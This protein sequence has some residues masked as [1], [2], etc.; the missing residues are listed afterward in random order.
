[1]SLFDFVFVEI[2]AKVANH[3]ILFFG[4]DLKITF[5]LSSFLN[6][7]FHM[8]EERFEI[9][10]ILFLKVGKK[11]GSVIV[12]GVVFDDFSG[13]DLTILRSVRVEHFVNCLN[14]FFVEARPH[15]S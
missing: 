3:V 10:G 14:L 8:D 12:I 11:L 1:M 4:F 9:H 15:I 2:Q 7:F 13:F 6:V 5:L